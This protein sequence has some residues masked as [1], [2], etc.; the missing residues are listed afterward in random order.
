[1]NNSDDATILL[2]VDARCLQDS[3]FALRGVGVHAAALLAAGCARADVAR[4]FRFVALTDPKLPS[5]APKYRA[6]FA[7]IRTTAYLPNG[8]PGRVVFFSPS[9]MTH[10]P[11]PIARLLLQPSTVLRGGRARFHPA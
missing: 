6:F 3:A 4:R 10:S 2:I 8:R 11:I 7:E 9:P 1:M 5:L